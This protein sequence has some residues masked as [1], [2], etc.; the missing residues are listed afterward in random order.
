MPPEN[1]DQDRVGF[2][3]SLYSPFH[4]AAIAKANGMRVE[5]KPKNKMGG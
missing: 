3:K 1:K 5:A 4:K 2:T